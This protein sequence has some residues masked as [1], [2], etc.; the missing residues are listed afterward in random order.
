[1]SFRRLTML[2]LLVVVTCNTP[3]LANSLSTFRHKKLANLNGVSLKFAATHVKLTY[4]VISC[5]KLNLFVWSDIL[6]FP[7]HNIL[8]MMPNG[9]YSDIG[10]TPFYFAWLTEKLNF[11]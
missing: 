8:T 5:C 11:T 10:S 7:P 6:Q 3:T 9:N 4:F 2:I 1:M